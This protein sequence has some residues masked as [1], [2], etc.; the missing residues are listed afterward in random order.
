MSRHAFDPHDGPSATLALVIVI[1][2]IAIRCSVLGFPFASPFA[3]VADLASIEKTV[4]I[5]F[6]L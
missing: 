6:P 1:T 2:H 4:K 3:Q 5:R